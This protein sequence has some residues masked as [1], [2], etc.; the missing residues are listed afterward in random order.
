[1]AIS[2]FLNP[3][4]N[5]GM[6][7]LLVI[8][9]STKA[10]SPVRLITIDP[11]H[12]HAAL[13]QKTMYSNVDPI[14]YVYAP[15]GDDLKMH[16]D[17]INTYN[18]RAENPTHWKEEIYTGNDF[19]VKMI[20][21]NTEA[22]KKESARKSVIILAG[23]NQKKTEYIFKSLQN[24]F[25]VF[26]DKPM[27]IDAAGFG[28]LKKSFEIAKKQQL[29]LYDIMTER[30][31]ITTILQRELSS[32]PVVFGQLEKGTLENPAIV[33]ESVHNF[34]KYVSGAVL[35]RP[36]WFLDAAQQGEGIVDVMTHLVDL[37]QWECFPEQKIDYLQDITINTAKRWATDITL[38]KF[39]EL[40][41]QEK[42]PAYLKANITDT[43]L[44]V[45]CN[46]EI[47]YMIKGVHAKTT[48]I[49]NYK[50]PVGAGDT[51]Y[52][53]MRGTKANIVIRQGVQEHYTATLYIEP[54]Q[55]YNE[56]ILREQFKNL[57]IK[58]P[59]IELKKSSA[60]WEVVIPEILKEGHESHFGKVTEKYL[61]YLTKGNI[62]AWEVP[63]MLAK[64]YTTIKGLETAL[65]N[66]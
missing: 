63:N 57:Q 24:G 22:S 17:R 50:A 61:E 36:A 21:D 18:L 38:S 66:K 26:A 58:Y 52:S 45:F 20:K 19:F 65:K 54:M 59:G 11:G 43:T 62:P 30:F 33:K 8:C 35:T 46:G 1:M 2:L 3:I 49:W 16:L 37:V 39:K 31:E 28:L 4:R 10:Q 6:I 55:A 42:F 23:N 64:Y 47:N 53:I 56:S 25:N 51:Y 41:K 40:T 14:V 44:K 5:W 48:A 9:N 27:V 15:K 29:L 13:V 32:M 7:F 12:F 34:Y 60:G